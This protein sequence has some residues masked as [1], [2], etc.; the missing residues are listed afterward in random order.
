MKSWRL[1]LFYQYLLSYVLVLLIP[2]LI[3]GMIVY[4]NF[5]SLTKQ[6]ELQ[7]NDEA[8]Q[9]I[10]D[11]VDTKFSE[12]MSIAFQLSSIPGLSSE[13]TK[14]PLGI[15]NV[16]AA[17][18]FSVGNEAIRELNLY[19]HG[20]NY[21]FSS[22]TTY[23]PELFH[24]TYFKKQWEYEQFIKQI[25]D[26]QKP[27]LVPSAPNSNDNL[28]KYM[29][30][31][32]YNSLKPTATAIF[33]IK[34][35]SLKGLFKPVLR[36]KESNSYV[37]DD[38]DQLII[39][40]RADTTD[41]AD[42]V[43]KI[44]SVGERGSEVITLLGTPYLLSYV[45][46]TT[47]GW[48][49]ATLVPRKEVMKPVNDI[50][51]KGVLATAIIIAI[52][53]FMIYL[54][55][56]YNYHPLRKL[57]DLTD[58]TWGPVIK[59][60]Y[61]LHKIKAAM[62]H[63]ETLSETL[64]TQTEKIGPALKEYLLSEL[65]KGRITSK[66]Q[67]NEQGKTVGL[68]LQHKQYC[69]QVMQLSAQVNKSHMS[70]SELALLYA[71]LLPENM[72]KF[73]VEMIDSQLVV[74]ILSVSQD[75]AH[76][77]ER[78]WDTVHKRYVEST[79]FPVTIGVGLAYDLDADCSRISSS[80]IEAVTALQ[81][82]VIKGSNQVIFFQD[83][84]MESPSLDWYPLKELERF[85]LLLRKRQPESALAE[86]NA[87]L[88]NMREKSSN[89]YAAKHISLEI[90]NRVMQTMNDIAG[91]ESL[92]Y[93]DV[94]AFV[95]YESF[96]ELE[97]TV[98]DVCMRAYHDLKQLDQEV[99]TPYGGM[100]QYIEQNACLYTFSVQSMA[101]HLGMSKVHLSRYF[102]DKANK[103]VMEVV[104]ELRLEEAK[105]LLKETGMPLQ[106]IVERIGYADVSSFIRKF[107]Q[108]MKLTPGEYRKLYDHQ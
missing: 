37:F 39:A 78:F 88:A 32:P 94:T 81:Y 1:S 102:K 52:G 89:L 58:R 40:L 66:Q 48:T 8:L 15:M 17:L 95:K 57:I 92:E 100:L 65:M 77:S 64:R 44:L 60:K 25:K 61:G 12:F 53:F 85:E 34:E 16:S 105:R 31:V 80:F 47:T 55:M 13:E 59:D 72:E 3:T 90:I 71:E 62:A 70:K 24:H 56:R 73:V 86:A 99:D 43:K 26:V 87:M 108:E 63:A 20:A 29:L 79:G 11:L 46:S 93:P 68:S 2:L 41:N 4:F 5:L 84:A 38:K 30:P 69:V 75:S 33:L 18:N 104:N 21:L 97:A 19:F 50:I 76:L 6:Q 45:K 35:E 96:E 7:K 27:L 98:K 91:K 23:T 67:L 82:K 28:I 106:N 9:Q 36:Y 107:K 14:E 10:R 103:T 51:Y 74:F 42:T 101:D 49:Y 22:E 54:S 83:T